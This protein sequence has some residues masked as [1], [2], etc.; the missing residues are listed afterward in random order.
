MNSS[1]IMAI[2]RT[3]PFFNPTFGWDEKGN[4]LGGGSRPLRCYLRSPYA[5][6]IARRRNDADSRKQDS[7]PR[8]HTK[9]CD[10][11]WQRS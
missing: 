8:E 1:C 6:V 11:G 4:C 9:V 5:Q 7:Q 3:K 10:R 2:T